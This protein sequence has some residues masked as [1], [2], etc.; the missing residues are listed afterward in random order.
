MRP[1]GLPA[2]GARDVEKRGHAVGYGP[3]AVAASDQL[4]S[5]VHRRREAHRA[6]TPGPGDAPLTVDELRRRHESDAEVSETAHVL[7][8]VDEVAAVRQAVPVRAGPAAERRL[9]GRRGH[10]DRA[11]AG[12]VHPELEP[13]FMGAAHERDQLVGVPLQV[14]PVVAVAVV[15]GAVDEDLHAAELQHLVPEARAEP[16]VQQRVERDLVRQVVEPERQLAG[17]LER[18][19]GGDVGSRERDRVDRRHAVVQEQLGRLRPDGL[20]RLLE[21]ERRQEIPDLGGRTC[22]VVP[23]RVMRPC[24]TRTASPSGRTGSIVRRRAL[25]RAKAS[26]TGLRPGALS[27]SPL[28]RGVGRRRR[29][30]TGHGAA[31]SIALPGR[32]QGSGTEFRSAWPGATRDGAD[33]GCERAAGR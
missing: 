12:D 26:S 4:E 28:G 24:S 6:W 15:A 9:Y 25:T 5:L 17:P 19:V 16:E 21:P 1:T 27:G 31:N 7:A 22:S 13:A 29:L 2:H 3:G 32:C 10:S 18:V 20:G 30:L 14:E 23:T 8:A 11:G 33:G